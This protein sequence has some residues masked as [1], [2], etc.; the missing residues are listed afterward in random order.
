[1]NNYR[2][3]NVRLTRIQY[4]RKLAHSVESEAHITSDIVCLAFFATLF[5]YTRL[6]PRLIKQMLAFRSS[7]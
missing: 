7:A 1:M 5:V 4:A 3:I 6:L 2:L